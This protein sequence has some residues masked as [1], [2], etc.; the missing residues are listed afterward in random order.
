VTSRL[1]LI[2]ASSAVLLATMVRVWRV[3]GEWAAMV[4]TVDAGVLGLSALA[5]VVEL[6]VSRG[7][8]RRTLLAA[9]ALLGPAPL[10]LYAAFHARKVFGLP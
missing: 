7:A 8:R 10:A 9:W 2:I 3:G 5:A 6:N 1:A 4:L